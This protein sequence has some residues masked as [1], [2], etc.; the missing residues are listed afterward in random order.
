M[1]EWRV[2][3]MV[4]RGDLMIYVAQWKS[5]KDQWQYDVP[6]AVIWRGY[7]PKM[8]SGFFQAPPMAPPSPGAGARHASWGPVHGH[9]RPTMSPGAGRVR[10]N[11]YEDEIQEYI[12]DEEDEGDE[13]QNNP[14]RR[15]SR[16]RSHK[17]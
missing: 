6:G 10:P 16:R 13:A 7:P 11:P 14:R 15:R 3:P 8:G 9:R 5:I 12:F 4:I 1:I 17:R 2:L